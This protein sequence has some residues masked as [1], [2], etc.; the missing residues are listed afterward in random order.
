VSA[1]DLPR[2]ITILLLRQGGLWKG[3]RFRDHKYIGDPLNTIRIFNDKEVDELFVLDITA[4]AERRIIP[5]ELVEK[6]AE[7]CYMPFGIGGG[8]RSAEEAG[9]LLR[10]GAEKVSINTAAVVEPRLISEMAERFGSQSVTVS[11]DVARGW[12]GRH[13][14]MTHSGRRPTRLDPVAW[15]VEAQKR[16]AGEILLTSIDRDGTGKGYDLD[17]IRD[18]TAAVDIPVIAGGGAG[19]IEDLGLAT[20]AGAAATAAGSLFIFVGRHRAVLVNY[21]SVAVRM[22]D[23][24]PA[25]HEAEKSLATMDNAS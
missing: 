21:P 2:A 19:K 23:G 1:N 7:E 3:V 17:L 5:L 4:T 13:R 14:V 10:A 12:L 16:G 20:E 25:I 15:A 24:R 8:I 11:I 9:R 18:V 22:A 6:M